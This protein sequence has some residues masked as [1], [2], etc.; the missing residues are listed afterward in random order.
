MH[1]SSHEKA[2][3]FVPTMLGAHRDA[4]LTVLD[5]GAQMV[6][7]GDRLTY[8]TLF[9][10]SAWTY[11]GLDVEPGTNVDVVP[12]DPYRWDELEADAFDVVVSGQAFEHVP[13]FWATAF[14]I[15][16]VLRPGGVA[17]IIAP[18]R[19]AQHRF[20]V[21]CWRF[22]DDGF[23]A[24]AELLGFEVLDVFTDW[25]RNVW[26]ESMIV[27]RKPVWTPAERTRFATRLWHQRAITSSSGADE[28][29]TG[30]E[31]AAPDT[32]IDTP[33]AHTDTL[34]DTADT[35][36]PTPSPLRALPTGQLTP[37]LEAIR[38]QAIDQRNAQRETSKSRLVRMMPMGLRTKLSKAIRGT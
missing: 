14:E 29:A 13:F 5:V 12:A 21:D 31:L 23:L 20:P 27:M 6:E 18:A 32:P 19:G 8:R 37:L 25:K 35:E 7:I 9:D 16:R 38:V 15:G 22:H 30:D 33:D 1:E 26:E 3:V 17:V 34:A 24:I 4:P 11:T 10:A 28:P 36:T 2:A